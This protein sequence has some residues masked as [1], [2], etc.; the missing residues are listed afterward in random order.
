MHWGCTSQTSCEA[1]SRVGAHLSKLWPYTENWAKR[2]FFCEWLCHKITY[3]TRICVALSSP[4]S[5][6]LSSLLSSLLSSR[7]SEI[8][9]LSLVPECDK[10]QWDFDI[11]VIFLAARWRISNFLFSQQ[12]MFN[13][14]SDALSDS[15]WIK[16][17]LTISSVFI[18]SNLETYQY[19]DKHTLH[20]RLKKF[21]P[22]AA[23]AVCVNIYIHT[24]IVKYQ[25]PRI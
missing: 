22:K 16:V 4:L 5:S 8:K 20:Y 2:A 1:R 19:W 17:P 23:Y 15:M 14:N 12:V 13:W 25:Y 21:F 7:V 24:Y 9:F 6:P 18:A 11:I 10:Y 3:S